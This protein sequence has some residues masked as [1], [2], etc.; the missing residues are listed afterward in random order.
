MFVRV[1]QIFHK[2]EHLRIQF[3]KAQ[4]TLVCDVHTYFNALC[5]CG[6]YNWGQFENWGRFSAAELDFFTVVETY[7]TLSGSP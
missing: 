6:G 1:V 2:Y 7:S 5:M 3:L 4:I